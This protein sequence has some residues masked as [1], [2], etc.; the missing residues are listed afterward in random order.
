[1]AAPHVIVLGLGI[2]GS[3][4][5]ASLAARGFRVTG[6]EQFA[7]L[8]ERGSSHGD[9]R[10]FRRVP[11]EGSIYVELAA[12]SYAGWHQWNCLARQELFVE[13]GGIDAGPESSAMVLSAE[14]LCRHYEQPFELL[15]GAKFNHRYP[16]FQ[17]PADWRVVYQPRSGV[18]RPAAT[19]VFLHAMAREAGA[20]LRHNTAVLEIEYLDHGVRVRTADTTRTADFLVVAAG[21]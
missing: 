3:S 10:I 11:H 8:H 16:S 9:T 14:D 13:C 20:T 7:P 18:V 21:S 1:L 2:A 4:I 5:A 15:N 17:L 12:A 19:R 6:I